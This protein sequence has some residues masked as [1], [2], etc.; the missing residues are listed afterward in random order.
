MSTAAPPAPQPDDGLPLVAPPPG[1]DVGLYV[2]LA[3]LLAGGIG[4]FAALASSR[5]EASVPATSGIGGG[6]ARIASPPPL[7]VPGEFT[8]AGARGFLPPAPADQRF[9]PAPAAVPV[10]TVPSAPLPPQPV[11]DAGPS[12]PAYVPP[13]A[14]Y[15]PPP[16]RPGLIEEGNRPPLPQ[17]QATE[18][19][20]ERVLARPFANPALTIPKG[21]VIP[22]VL[23]TAIDS[24][25]AGGV[26]A[27]VQRDVHGFD[28]SRVLLPRGSRLYGEYEA[29]GQGQRRALVTWTRAMRP[30]G[31]VIALDSPASDPLG[32][33]GIPGRVDSKFLARFGNAILQS[34]LD[35]GVGVATAA[36]T[37]GVV[38]LPGAVRPQAPQVADNQ[39]I[40]PTLKVRH[41]TSVSVFVARDLDFS[42]VGG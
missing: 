33:A 2:F 37:D 18:A 16:F 32:R 25:Q 1:R 20:G 3:I 12:A 40:Q 5:E 27:L 7:Q 38:V 42:A 9:L 4:L 35:L 36:A 22:A 41:G 34:A 39:Q 26:R 15:D 10:R 6:G 29:I 13:Q 30:D 11:R 17:Q 23:E 19:D 28:G 31:V 24:T 21:T 14:R 8:G